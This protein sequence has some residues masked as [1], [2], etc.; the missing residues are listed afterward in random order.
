MQFDAQQCISHIVDLFYPWTNN[1]SG[2]DNKSLPDNCLFLING[3]ETI[4]CHKC[5]RYANKNFKEALCPVAFPQPD[6]ETSIQPK[7]NQL[8]TYPH[9]QQMDS[10][11]ECGHCRAY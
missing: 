10:L 6:V 1:G 11:Y 3:E 2:D 4:L 7:F 5:N 9:R 8:I